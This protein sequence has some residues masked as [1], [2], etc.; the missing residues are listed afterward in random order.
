MKSIRIHYHAP[1]FARS[2]RGQSSSSRH[3]VSSATADGSAFATGAAAGA[4]AATGS[5]FSFV[6]SDSAARPAAPPIAKA[7]PSAVAEDTTCLDELD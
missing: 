2:T 7:D 6:S 1:R 3:V 5:T 4:A